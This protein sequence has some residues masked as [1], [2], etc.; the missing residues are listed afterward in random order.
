M[1][2]NKENSQLNLGDYPSVSWLLNDLDV[3]KDTLYNIG[4]YDIFFVGYDTL[5]IPIIRVINSFKTLYKA[6]EV[7]G[8]KTFIRL[9]FDIILNLYAEYKYDTNAIKKIYAKGAALNDVRYKGEKLK[10]KEVRKELIAEYPEL[11]GIY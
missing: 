7:A 11:E 10:P 3:A 6:N 4:Y 9:M 8:A 2:H 5:T 1:N